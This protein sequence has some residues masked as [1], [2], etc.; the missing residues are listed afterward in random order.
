[1]NK[2]TRFGRRLNL[3]STRQIIH[4]MRVLEAE[5][6]RRKTSLLETSPVTGFALGETPQRLTV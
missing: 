1:M 6:H 2:E 3:P 5:E 4:E